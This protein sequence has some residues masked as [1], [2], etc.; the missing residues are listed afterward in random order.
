MARHAFTTGELSGEIYS[1]EKLQT[2]VINGEIELI[3]VPFA[4]GSIDSFLSGYGE[5]LITVPSPL[6]TTL[7]YRSFAVNEID[8]VV[9]RALYYAS[10]LS[11]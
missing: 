9:V 8:G 3:D 4:G 1:G 11:R 6:G 7:L 10:G 2:L 5:P